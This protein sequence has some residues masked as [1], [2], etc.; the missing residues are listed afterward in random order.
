EP[1]ITSF[2]SKGAGQKL[3]VS[4]NGREQ[5][6]QQP[7]AV[8]PDAGAAGFTIGSRE[9]I[10]P[11]AQ[12]W[13]G[14]LAEVLVYDRELSA[15]E[16]AEA[17]SYLATKYALQTA[18]RTREAAAMSLDAADQQ[19]ADRAFLADFFFAAF[20]RPATAEELDMALRHM[21]QVDSRRDGLEDVCWA[22]LNSKEF[23]FQH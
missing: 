13:S 14:E 17:G 7:G 21:A 9:D 18:Y 11:G 6:V 8:G 1:F 16:L 4:V 19:A 2:V 23:L 5:P 10:P 12:N 15:E 22:V 3:L 20:S